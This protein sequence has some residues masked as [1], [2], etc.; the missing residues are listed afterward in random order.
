M[1]R[2]SARYNYLCPVSLRVDELSLP[3]ARA[4]QLFIDLF[5]RCGEDRL[6]EPVG[7]L[8][9]G[10]VPRPSVQFFGPT[11]PVGDHVVHVAHENRVVREVEQAGLLCSFGHFD[12]EFI[13]S[14]PKLSLDPASPGAEPGHY[15]RE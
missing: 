12:L 1:H 6:H 10:L 11:V 13:P 4:E 9:D 15:A 14:F 2:P 5:E 8:P 3:A 7:D